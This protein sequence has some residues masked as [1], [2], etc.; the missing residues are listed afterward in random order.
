MIHNHLFIEYDQIHDLMDLN[1]SKNPRVAFHCA[2]PP[3]PT[4][5]WRRPGPHSPGGEA[6]KR[7][8]MRSAEARNLGFTLW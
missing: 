3:L 1:G 4:T 2:P 6:A 8:A 7:V 5:P